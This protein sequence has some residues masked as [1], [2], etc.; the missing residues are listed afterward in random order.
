MFIKS[1]WSEMHRMWTRVCEREREEKEECVEG[2]R[3]KE[4]NLK[5]NDE[6]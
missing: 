2:G 1:G 3:D 5:G 6:R 4:G